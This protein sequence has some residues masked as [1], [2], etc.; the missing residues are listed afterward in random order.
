MLI[1]TFCLFDQNY[2]KRHS[3]C[4]IT[5]ELEV[6]VHFVPW[7]PLVGLIR[8]PDHSPKQLVPMLLYYS[9]YST[10]SGRGRMVVRFTTTCVYHH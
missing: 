4:C 5:R 6:E 9:G 10:G 8:P 2:Q 7:T 1:N 3:F